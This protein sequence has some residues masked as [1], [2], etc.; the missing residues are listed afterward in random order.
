VCAVLRN[1]KPQALP[2]TQ[3]AQGSGL[4]VNVPGAATFSGRPHILLFR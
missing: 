2:V 3:I 4:T 1:G